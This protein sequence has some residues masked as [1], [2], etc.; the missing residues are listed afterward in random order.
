M[1]VIRQLRPGTGCLWC[2]GLI[3]GTQLA[4]EAKTDEERKAQDY[5]VRKANPS[6]ITLNAV[7]AGHAVND[8]LFD[9]PDLRAESGDAVYQHHH[10]LRNTAQSVIPRKDP[11]GRGRPRQW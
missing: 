7:A 6:V 11:N 9:F 10:F 1:R 4:L 8:F 2:N 3:D 5:G